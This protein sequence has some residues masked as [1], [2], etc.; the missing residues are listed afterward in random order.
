MAEDLA[1]LAVPQCR[2]DLSKWN[3][4]GKNKGNILRYLDL[5]DALREREAS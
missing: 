3:L 5:D 1:P 4:N 2:V